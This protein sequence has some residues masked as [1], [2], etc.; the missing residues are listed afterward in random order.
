MSDALDIDQVRQQLQDERARRI[1][2]EEECD[3]LSIEVVRLNAELQE[4]KDAYPHGPGGVAI[5]PTGISDVDGS[6]DRRS[7]IK[8]EDSW[9]ELLEDGDG[10][11]CN[12]LLLSVKDA[13]GGKNCIC[14]GFV[15]FGS[16]F[17]DAV[18]S[19]GADNTIRLFSSV[20][21][22]ELWTF[23][24]SAPVLCIDCQGCN[25]V[26]S[27]MDGAHYIVSDMSYDCTWGS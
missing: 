9:M 16:S 15:V 26:A 19:G 2:L 13:C 18:V 12:K 10:K 20:D 3:L 11:Y 23:T 6:K 7:S 5:D 1:Q 27:C 8:N 14:A 24:A 22:G 17:P 4:Y 21:G 25:V